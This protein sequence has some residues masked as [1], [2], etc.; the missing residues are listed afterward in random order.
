MPIAP[1][2]RTR[3][4]TEGTSVLWNCRQ[5]FSAGS[6][7]RYHRAPADTGRRSS[8]PLTRSPRSGRPSVRNLSRHPSDR[9]S[10][11]FRST[12]LDQRAR[13]DGWSVGPPSRL[14]RSLHVRHAVESHRYPIRGARRTVRLP[15]R[16]IAIGP[17]YTQ[18]FEDRYD[19]LTRLH[20]LTLPERATTSSPDSAL[21]RKAS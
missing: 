12:A 7:H 3:T 2:E 10:R 9:L 6:G 13:P 18:F 15:D 17:F 5:E 11:D 4:K 16:R 20:S 21:T 1:F 19:S 8:S 14:S